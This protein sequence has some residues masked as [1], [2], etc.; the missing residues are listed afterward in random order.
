MNSTGL[1]AGRKR[2]ADSWRWTSMSCSFDC[3][4]AEWS[5]ALA[6]MRA[7]RRAGGDLGRDVVRDMRHN[8]VPYLLVGIG[9]AGLV[10]A[11][12]SFSRRRTRARLPR[13]QRSGLRAAALAP[14]NGDPAGQRVRDFN[15]RG[16]SGIAYRR[17]AGTGDQ[18]GD[19]GRAVSR[20]HGRS[21]SS[22]SRQRE[23]DSA[24][25]AMT[26]R[27]ERGEHRRSG[28]ASAIPQNMVRCTVAPD[29]S[30]RRRRT[31]AATPSARATYRSA[32]GRTFCG[33]SMRG[34]ARTAS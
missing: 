13:V 2:F 25:D 9:I 3:S 21:A 15:R 7:I 16:P 34:S 10:W 32:A 14:R 19:F 27:R 12:S 18:P 24:A 20:G 4:R 30:G 29:R 6:C 1:S 8:P 5:E 17:R 11:V 33:V 23:S 22:R 28:A 31:E 26:A